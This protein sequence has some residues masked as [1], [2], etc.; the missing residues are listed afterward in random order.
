[1][2]GVER[3]VIRMSDYD[4]G[5][6]RAQRAYDNQMPPEEDEKIPCDKCEESGYLPISA[7]CESEIVDHTCVECGQACERAKCDKCDGKGEYLPVAP[8]PDFDNEND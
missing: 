5:F 2:L 8:E 3:K 7:C 4:N 6:K 1:M